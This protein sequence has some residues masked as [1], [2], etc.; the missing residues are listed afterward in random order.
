MSELFLQISTSLDGYI[1]DPRGSIDWMMDDTSSD[2]FHTATLQSIDG[3]IFGRTAHVLLADFWPTAAATPDASPDLIEQ[4]R[5]MNALPKYVLTHGAERT[6]WASSHAISVGEV[7]R[8][9]E[10]AA[11]P[12]AAFAGAAMAQAL[13][14]RGLIDE[15]RVIQYPILLGGGTPLFAKDGIRRKLTLTGGEDFS[16]GATLRRYSLS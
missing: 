11:R 9:K 8:L 13:L 2:A 15:I 10:A 7:L 3:M 14:E 12:I 1:E 5:L 16:S 6:G 4:A